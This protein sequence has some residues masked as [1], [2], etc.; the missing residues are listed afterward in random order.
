MMIPR[1]EDGVSQASR[2]LLWTSVATV[3][4][5]LFWANWAELD[6]VTRA[7]G[8][9]IVSSRNQVIQSPDGGVLERMLVKE[10]D[11]VKRGQVLFRFDQTRAGAGQQESLAKAVSLR[12][13]VAR[14]QAEVFGGE[15]RFAGLSGFSETHANQLAL[16]KR[17]QS[18]I[19]EEIAALEGSLALVKS[20]LDMNLPLLKS[21][22][23]SRAEVLKLQRQVADIQGQIT[24]RRNKYFQDA[25]TELAKAQE[26]LESVEQV[27]NQRREQLAYTEVRAPM[28][29]VVRNVR[30]TT[31][32]GVAKPGD[33]IL[34]IVP[35]EDDLIVE[36]KVRPADVAFIKPGLSATVKLDAYDYSI[37]GSLQGTVSYISADTLTEATSAGEMPYYRV[38]IKTRDSNLS[39][40]KDER[41]NIQP[42]MT[43]TVEIKTGKQ[44]VLRYL[45]KPITKTLDESLRER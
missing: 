20:E 34:Q 18:A 5:F 45:T 2:L 37:Y 15:P 38:Q 6:K 26:D 36:A 12:A 19:Q 32:G 39:S 9:V 8:Q 28:D 3:A 41:I 30:L 43:A 29:G 7:T 31:Q 1:T 22:D 25:Q 10:G 13:A 27:L 16:F 17:R 44:T 4:G 24:N 40:R 33:E 14:L 11:A 35:L 42:G 21:G 23:V